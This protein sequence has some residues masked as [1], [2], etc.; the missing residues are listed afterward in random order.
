MARFASVS[1]A[2]TGRR[3]RGRVPR[4]AGLWLA[5][6]GLAV[7]LLG[8]VLGP[9]PVF[10]LDLVLLDPVP[11]PRGAWGLGPELPRRVPLW[12]VV[13]WLAPVLSGELLGKLLMAGS[14]T[15]AFV[16]AHR[17]TTMLL[18]E[19]ASEA[20]GSPGGRPPPP[21]R[22]L[23]RVLGR[24]P[25]ASSPA[26]GRN[27]S[28]GA[29]PSPWLA[30][31]AGVLYAASPFL[32]TR[33]AVGHL[34]VAVPMAL[35]PWTLPHLLRPHRSLPAT[36]LAAAALGFA[37]H[38]GGVLALAVAGIGLVVSRRRDLA[39]VASVVVLAQLPW[40]VP[41]LV[42]AGGATPTDATPFATD[43]N[44]P[45]GILDL[46]A[47]HG[48]WQPGYQVGRDVPVA[49]IGA[50]V[51]MLAVVGAAGLPARW[52]APFAALAA[53]GLGGAAASA[54]PVVREGFA[55]LTRLPGAGAL[56]ESQ[57]ALVLALVVI[58]PCA[59]L[60]A[61][62]LAAGAARVVGGAPVAGGGAPRREGLAGATAGAVASV[63]LAAGVALAVPAVGGID[64][65]LRP[66]ALPSAWRE[67]R[68]AVEAAPG[69]V[70]ALPWHQYFDVGIDGVRRVLNPVPLLVGGDVLLSSDPELDQPERRERIDPR[71]ST[72]DGIVAA[73]REGHPV[74]ARLAALGVRWV[75]VLHEADWRRDGGIGAQD[76]GLRPVVRASTLDLWEVRS[77]P[78]L[79]VGAN[80]AVVVPLIEPLLSVPP[81][82]RVLNRPYAAGWLRG[83]QPAGEA[84]GGLLALPEGGGPVWFWPALLVL[85]A[86]ALTAAGAWASIRARRA[87]RSR[88]PVGDAPP[89]P[90]VPPQPPVDDRLPRR[91]P[92][93]Y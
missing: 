35:L 33:L 48:F 65:R 80:T 88:R 40:L 49:A 6:A 78:G 64:S 47:G 36:F 69:T 89:A 8:P 39:G 72:A 46:V 71:E 37:G 21:S 77:W 62:R 41:G 85:L 44:G 67:A 79:G 50:L 43:V 25:S 30:A 10:T 52:R 20:S 12:T 92:S 31:G 70:L 19:Q 55:T 42:V 76:A 56:R 59:A 4:G 38:V 11:V 28:P 7:V 81:S 5:G 27:L 63:V 14:I 26:P 61:G 32:L 51:A 16:G 75:L 15:V 74:S 2:P 93:L 86:D 45:G 23:S 73:A 22:S 53:V 29:R 60:G 66:V 68:A 57:R 24:Q 83:L 90:D 3:W 9:G 1:A 58:A 91:K 84:P 13:A 18:A 17:L 54:V 87:G 34:M 82:V